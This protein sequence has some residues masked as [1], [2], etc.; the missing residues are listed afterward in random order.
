MHLNANKMLCTTATDVSM[1][2]DI[3]QKEPSTNNFLVRLLIP[4]TEVIL[5]IMLCC[6]HSVLVRKLCI[7]NNVTGSP[8]TGFI[9]LATNTMAQQFFPFSRFQNIFSFKYFA[10]TRAAGVWGGQ[11]WYVSQVH[12]FGLTWNIPTHIDLQQKMCKT[13]GNPIS[14]RLVFTNNELIFRK[15][16]WVRVRV[17]T[18]WRYICQ[19]SPCCYYYCG[20]VCEQILAFSSKARL[21]LNRLRPHRAA[22]MAVDSSLID[23]KIKN[24]KNDD[25]NYW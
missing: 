15:L 1:V 3:M 17:K 23:D 13:D 20:N 9:G 8:L 11:C 14:L 19:A 4:W 7:M 6:S 22:N 5:M 10:A 16:T 12:Y 2:T 24:K 25:S 18:R 21:C